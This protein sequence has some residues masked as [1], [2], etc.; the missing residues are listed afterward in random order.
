VAGPQ[1]VDVPS[2][3]FVALLKPEYREAFR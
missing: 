3:A 2:D 1:A